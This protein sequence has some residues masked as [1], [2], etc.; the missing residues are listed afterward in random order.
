[1]INKILMVMGLLT[2]FI[3]VSAQRFTQQAALPAI[4]SSRVYNIILTPKI[5]GASKSAELSD[6][7]IYEGKTE[8]PY[9]IQQEQ[10]ND[11]DFKKKFVK[12]DIL[13][14]KQTPNG[15]STLIFHNPQSLKLDHFDMYIRNTWVRKQ[16]SIS[17]S[18]DRKKWYA[19]TE[20]FWLDLHGQFDSGINR[21]IQTVQIPLTDYKYYC[22]SINDSATKPINIFEIGL[23]NLIAKE[24]S[25]IPVPSPSLTK[26]KEITPK[27]TVLKLEFSEAY[28]IHK[29]T[30]DIT[31]PNLYHR[32]ATLSTA[33][34]NTYIPQQQFT[35]TSGQPVQIIL[36]NAIKEKTLYLFI[37]N[38]D[39]PPLQ[40]TDIKAWQLNTYL[41]AYLEKGKS[42]MLKT[43][44]SSLQMPEYDFNYYNSL[45][46]IPTLTPGILR[47]TA[48]QEKSVIITPSIFKSKIWIWAGI[49]GINLLIGLLV[50]KLI[51]DMQ[52]QKR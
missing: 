23:Y 27:Q 41:T 50:F 1:M 16:I 24:A 48:T 13:E 46:N 18:D 11:I 10:N 15:I 4:D 40:I 19:V 25:Y 12:F 22:L 9:V 31:S 14:N 43:G 52:K 37:E 28:S 34:G 39:N 8:I 45:V 35:L 30:F 49:A 6:I 38:K 29:L 51:K 17:G 44:D 3:P 32:S 47:I 7:R 2:G 33:R 42:Y 20:N 5:T 21:L 36:N 26:L